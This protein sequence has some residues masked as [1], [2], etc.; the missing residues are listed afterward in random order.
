MIIDLF[1]ALQAGKELANAATWKKAQLWT[2]NLTILLGAA[3]SIAAAAGHPLPLGPEQI[4]TLVSALAVLVGLFNSY[5]TVAST[6]KLGVPPGP[7]ADDP[8]GAD[9]GGHAAVSRR[10]G[11]WLRE[12]DDRAPPALHDV[13]P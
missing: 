1:R 10:P 13:S 9:R 8:G 11:E 3:V 2:S 12:L 7:G 4:T 5:V 6:K